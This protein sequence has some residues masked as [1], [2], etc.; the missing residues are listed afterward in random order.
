MLGALYGDCLG[1][2]YEAQTGPMTTPIAIGPSV[3]GHSAGR[4]TDDT[5]TTVAAEGPPR[6]QQHDH[7]D[8]Q[9]PTFLTRGPPPDADGT[10]ADGLAHSPGPGDPRSGAAG[11]HS[12]AD[13]PC[14]GI[15]YAP[16]AFDLAIWSATKA[17]DFVT[18]IETIIRIGGDT[19]TN[20]AICGAVLAARFDFPT[21][22][23]SHLDPARVDELTRLGRALSGLSTGQIRP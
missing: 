13:I 14:P 4:G 11:E 23:A 6:Q 7:G 16:Y 10:T 15:G 18:G 8:R 22:L 20:G 9:A 17:I 2:R 1:A 12:P 19:D 21:E 3:F 5:E